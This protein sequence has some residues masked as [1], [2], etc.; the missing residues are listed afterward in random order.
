MKWL[1]IL[2]DRFKSEFLSTYLSCL[3]IFASVGAVLESHE[4]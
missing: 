2:C 4:T 3:N 1:G